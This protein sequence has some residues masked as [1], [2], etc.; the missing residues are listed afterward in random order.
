MAKFTFPTTQI[1]PTTSSKNI[2]ETRDNTTFSNLLSI[3][4]LFAVVKLTVLWVERA[5]I[6]AV[7]GLWEEL[8]KMKVFKYQP[9]TCIRRLRQFCRIKKTRCT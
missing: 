7:F 3:F 2:F 1:V 4:I 8:S 9:I 6:S 5:Y